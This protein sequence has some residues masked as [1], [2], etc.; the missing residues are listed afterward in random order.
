MKNSVELKVYGY[1]ISD[2]STNL[3][4]NWHYIGWPYLESMEVTR[5][6]NSLNNNY[7]KIYAYDSVNQ[8]WESFNPYYSIYQEKINT[9]NYLLVC[10]LKDGKKY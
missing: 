6:L 10:N 7:F 8:R 5:G 9:A 2:F 1:E 3:K 4:E